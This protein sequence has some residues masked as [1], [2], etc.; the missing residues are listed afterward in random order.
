[1][2][3]QDIQPN[4]W[5]SLGQL[6]GHN[7]HAIDDE[8]ILKEIQPIAVESQPKIEDLEL[9]IVGFTLLTSPLADIASFRGSNLS[10]STW[11]FY[12]GQD[13]LYP[14]DEAKN[15][16]NDVLSD[17]GN[18]GSTKFLQPAFII[19][20]PSGKDL[21]K[22]DSP[23]IPRTTSPDVVY[24]FQLLLR[25]EKGTYVNQGEYCKP[26]DNSVVFSQSGW[27]EQS[28][29]RSGSLVLPSYSAKMAPLE[30]M[31]QKKTDLK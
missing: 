8:R 11:S 24:K 15:E 29:G 25:S 28:S 3:N 6:F 31:L 23:N 14:S 30:I 21:Y 22:P 9:L 4:R 1:M 7:L 17:S 16:D 5:Y 12:N 10:I 13:K 2:V 18:I 27:V 19:T 26:P 20:G